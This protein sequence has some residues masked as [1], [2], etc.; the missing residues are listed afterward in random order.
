[1]I[2]KS[3]HI[4]I[5]VQLLLLTVVEN[6]FAALELKIQKNQTVSGGQIVIPIQINGVSQ[7]EIASYII[8][9]DY[10]DTNLSNP[11]AIIEGTLSADKDVVSNTPQDGKEGKFVITM[12][13]GF[14]ALEDGVLVKMQLDVNQN[15][16]SSDISFVTDKTVLANA[17]Y[18]PLDYSASDGVLIAFD[19]SYEN[20]VV[21]VGKDGAEVVEFSEDGGLRM[22]SSSFTQDGYVVAGHNNGNTQFETSA[23]NDYDQVLSRSWYFDIHESKPDTLTIR[24]AIPQVDEPI[25]YYGLLTATDDSSPSN[26]EELVR[27]LVVDNDTV[28]FQLS[29]DQLIEKQYYTVGLKFQPQ[30][31]ET[32]AHSIPTINEWGLI[33]FAG[34]LMAISIRRM[35]YAPVKRTS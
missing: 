6:S 22:E 4:V 18:T 31:T 34:I 32:H 16:T 23:L 25:S 14:T 29:S 8:R 30:N 28:V 9:L 35:K 5:F 21:S 3:I 20:N 26:F 11:V 17:S 13:S 10:D 7:A 27:P 12:F 33:I 24:F 1:M 15:F 2:L 19:A